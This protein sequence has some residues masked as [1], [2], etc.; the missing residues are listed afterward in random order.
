MILSVIW[1][2]VL[3]TLIKVSLEYLFKGFCGILSIGV[4]GRGKKYFSP[5]KK[6]KGG[7]EPSAS[8]SSPTVKFWL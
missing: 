1:Q 3:M 5:L 7:E 4:V 2:N 8:G 6:V